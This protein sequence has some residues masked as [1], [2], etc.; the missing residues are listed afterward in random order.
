VGYLPNTL[1]QYATID[2]VTQTYDANGNLTGDGTRSFAW[3]SESQL[4][5]ATVGST[6]ASYAYDP[7]GRR[8]RKTVDEG[9]GPADTWFVWGGDR[10][11]EEHDDAG[12]LAARYIYGD[13]FA[14]VRVELD[15]GTGLAPYSVHVDHLDTPRML[16]DSAGAVAW[17][18]DYWAFGDAELDG[19]NQ[20]TFNIRFPGQYFDAET[21]LHYNRFR[22]YDPEVGR[23]VSA[24]PIG[25]YGILDRFG[26][27]S[28]LVGTRF[29]TASENL[30][31]YSLNAPVDHFDP[32]GRGVR[33]AIVCVA[34][35]ALNALSTVSE[36]KKLEKQIADVDEQL[37]DL[38]ADCD[39]DSATKL[40]RKLDLLLEKNRIVGER[41]KAL[42]EGTVIGTAITAACVPLVV[43][44]F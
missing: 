12:A 35:Q 2:G 38:E 37:A 34:A 33:G 24:D 32:D 21:G 4:A 23:Y 29:P 36:A 17:A 27:S 1:N 13:G 15:S 25:Q 42:A 19:A 40:E 44:P 28:S 26:I 31:E 43:G 9:G 20:V 16:T 3:D 11:L 6:T 8:I 30:Y 22:Y 14:P 18:T 39:L 7:F 41:T 5:T 10:L